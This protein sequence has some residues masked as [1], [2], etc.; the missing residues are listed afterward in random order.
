MAQDSQK[1]KPKQPATR[2]TI[3]HTWAD[4]VNN[5]PND[6]TQTTYTTPPNRLHTDTEQTI[7][8]ERPAEGYNKNISMLPPAE[9]EMDNM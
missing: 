1:R 2:R 7:S 4:I 6:N 8:L 9:T 3:Q 5:E